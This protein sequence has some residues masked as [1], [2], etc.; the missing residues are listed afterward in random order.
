MKKQKYIL[1]AF[2]AAQRTPVR[3]TTATRRYKR[4]GKNCLAYGWYHIQLRRQEQAVCKAFLTS[5]LDMVCV[6]QEQLSWRPLTP[7]CVR[8]ASQKRPLED[9]ICTR[10]YEKAKVYSRLPKKQKCS[11]NPQNPAVSIYFHERKK[12][13]PVTQARDGLGSQESLDYRHFQPCLMYFLIAK[14]RT[15]R[16]LRVRTGPLSKLLNLENLI[17]PLWLSTRPLIPVYQPGPYRI[18]YSLHPI[19][20]LILNILMGCLPRQIL[21]IFL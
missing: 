18:L 7:L 16:D 14:L 9:A 4:T 20:A 8:L 11:H 1:D 6:S 15:R 5:Q 17:F 12:G 3:F 10:Y 19:P 13:I 2:C 21:L